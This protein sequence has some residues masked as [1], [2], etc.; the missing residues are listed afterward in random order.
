M[1]HSSCEEMDIVM[2]IALYKSN[3]FFALITLKMIFV[4]RKCINNFTDISA[5]N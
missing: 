3:I 5:P 1:G 2:N 4:Q